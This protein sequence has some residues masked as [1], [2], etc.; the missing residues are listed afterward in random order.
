MSLKE[1]TMRWPELFDRSWPEIFE[2]PSVT[3]LLQGAFMGS[4]LT[5][6]LGFNW[7]GWVLERTATEKANDTS[8]ALVAVL[9]PICADKLQNGPNGS[10]NLV[11]F[12]KVE[13]WQQGLYVQRGGWATFEGMHQPGAGVARACADIVAAIPGGEQDSFKS[14]WR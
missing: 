14:K 9:A 6:L 8:E 11:G 2:R 3:R 5:M 13:S 7:G 12:R 10:M 1:N 4:V